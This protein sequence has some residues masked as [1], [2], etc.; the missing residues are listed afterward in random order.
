MSK[1]KMGI[2]AASAASIIGIMAT[3]KQ[4]KSAGNEKHMPDWVPGPIKSAIS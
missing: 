2:M 3:M 1:K 4:R